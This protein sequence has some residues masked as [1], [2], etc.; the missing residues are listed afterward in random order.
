MEINFQNLVDSNPG[1]CSLKE[2]QYIGALISAHS[3]GNVLIFGVGNDTPYWIDI[4]PGGLTLFLEDNPSWIRKVSSKTPGARIEEIHYTT[5]RWWWKRIIDQPDKLQLILPQIVH[6]TFWDVIFVDAPR[7]NKG[8]FPGRMQSIFSASKLKYKHIL[9]HDCNRKVEHAYF[10][11][12]IG[13][14]NHILDR[15]F[16]KVN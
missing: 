2:Y 15:L 12:Y 5:R 6:E 4:N 16:H 14:P 3:P 13:Q 9:V 7:G 1:N 8:R 11:K 10:E